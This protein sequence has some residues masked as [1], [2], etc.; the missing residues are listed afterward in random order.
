MTAVPDSGYETGTLVDLPDWKAKSDATIG[1]GQSARFALLRATE[2]GK[3]RVEM[4]LR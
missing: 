1:T 2:G 3:Y 4:V